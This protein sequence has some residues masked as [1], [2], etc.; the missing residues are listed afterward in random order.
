[1]FNIA[2]TEILAAIRD[3]GELTSM[4][5][6][7]TTQ[8]TPENSSMLLLN[9]YRQGLLHRRKLHGKTMGYSITERGLERLNWLLEHYEDGS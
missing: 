2:K 7:M 4:E 6:S 1:M 3:L 5:I 9:Y 8:R